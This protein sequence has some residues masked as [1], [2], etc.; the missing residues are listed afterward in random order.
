MDKQN[1]VKPTSLDPSKQR[2]QNSSLLAVV[3]H[4]SLNIAQKT[5]TTIS[6]STRHTEYWKT[7]ALTLHPI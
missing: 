2:K 5:L 3:N 1:F 4:S 7:A 6:Y